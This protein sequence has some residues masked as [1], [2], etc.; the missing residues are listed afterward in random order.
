MREIQLRI[1]TSCDLCRN[2]S[3]RRETSQELTKEESTE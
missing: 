3:T 1:Q 2:A